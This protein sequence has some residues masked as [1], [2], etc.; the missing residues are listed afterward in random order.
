MA[1]IQITE[2]ESFDTWR[3]RINDIATNQGDLVLL[4]TTATSDLVAAINSI[5]VGSEDDQRRILIRAIFMAQEQIMANL[6]NFNDIIEAG[7]GN[8]FVLV[9]TGPVGDS[10]FKQFDLM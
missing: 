4:N 3:Q 6:G 5:L 2:N 7:I 1:L 10:F 8:T 9:Y